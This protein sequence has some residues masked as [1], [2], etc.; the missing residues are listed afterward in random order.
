MYEFVPDAI[1]I[2]EGILIIIPVMIAWSHFLDI[3]L[4]VFL[5]D[6]LLKKDFLIL[7]ALLSLFRY[8]N[9]DKHIKIK[10]YNNCYSIADLYHFRSI[11]VSQ[12]ALHSLLSFHTIL[13][14]ISF[15]YFSTDDYMNAAHWLADEL[16][17]LCYQ[18]LVEYYKRNSLEESFPSLPTVLTSSIPSR[19][20]FSVS[21]LV[22]PPSLIAIQIVAYCSV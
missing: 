17:C 22:S 1:C 12:G 20:R 9:E 5:N 11:A 21:L 6:F 18:D 8:D 7:Q 4:E 13:W 16:F 19:G 14:M 10:F 2:R 3:S 15:M